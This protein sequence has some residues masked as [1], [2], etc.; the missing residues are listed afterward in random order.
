MLPGLFP[1]TDSANVS[2][3]DAGIGGLPAASPLTAASTHVAHGRVVPSSAAV[4]ISADTVKDPFA[5]PALSVIR[6]G[7]PGSPAPERV[8]VSCRR[9]L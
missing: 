3:A 5:S 6:N 8:D 4:G 7:I 1:A 2:G 9:E